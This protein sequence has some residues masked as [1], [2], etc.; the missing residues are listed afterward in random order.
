VV[1]LGGCNRTRI[2]NAA[3]TLAEKGRGGKGW[4]VANG[5]MGKIL[6][7]DLSNSGLRVEAL[8]PKLARD[9]IGGYG[10][11]A[12]LLYERMRPG[13]DPLGPEN[14]L[15]FVTGP[16]TGTPCIE[17]NRSLVVC[18]SPLTGGWGDANCGGTFGAG[19][20]FAGFD[21]VFFTGA[22]DRPV[23]L[24]I[25]DGRAMLHEA[26]DLWGHDTNETERVLKERH[27]NGTEVASI[28][29]AGEKLAL[30]AAI[31][32]DDGRAWGRSGVGAV[33]GSKKLKA[34]SVKGKQRVP[35]ANPERARDLRKEYLKKHTGAYDLFNDYGTPGI[36]AD[37]S[38]SG[39]TPVKNWFGAGPA[40]FPQGKTSFEADLIRGEYQDKKYGCW[41][42]TMACGG[43]W[44]VKEGPYKGTKHHQP[45]Y[46][47]LGSF[48][49]MMLND[50]VG[51][52]VKSN[53]ICNRMGL[54]TISAA[55][56]ISW[57]MDCYNRGILTS[58]DTD[59]IDLTWGNYAG[60]VAALE[61]LATRDGPF[62]DLLAQG[63]KRAA[64]QVGRG[65]EVCA[66]HVG[67]QEL[68][69][70][71]PRFIP[72]LALTYQLDATPGR[73]TQ[74]GEM[75]AWPDMQDVPDKYDYG[76]KG[77]FHRKLVGAMHF[78]NS[79]GVCQFG[80]GSYPIETWTAFYAAIVGQE[81]TWDE[82]LHIGERIANLRLA[83]N[84][85]ENINPLTAHA[86]PGIVVGSPPLATG[87]LRG[88]TVDVQRQ[89]TDYLQAAGW[90]PQTCRPSP[91]KLEELGLQ[92]LVGDLVAT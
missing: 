30:I 72:G 22:A 16:M 71:D 61:K 73:H 15:G 63:V 91:A 84:L 46:E 68:P 44:S 9:F 32:N 40:D 51:S 48:G 18:K 8:D 13:V 67:G 58:D 76:A 27:G 49:T 86:I 28:G 23:Y 20:K 77:E 34:V 5:Y 52:I 4:N 12:R 43:H 47:T 26:D 6:W 55:G 37:S 75:G 29:P 35:V 92:F 81:L 25:D 78:I 69:M 39:D 62:C 87:N 64:E 90:D 7:V 24:E 59:G 54:D 74:G 42:C 60:I 65:S 70:H 80:F 14:I 56:V 10:I 82:A 33:M 11:G 53:E 83:F 41:M 2:V 45:E 31:I 57:A 21:A 19:L 1:A 79:L 38:W 50:N 89:V 3:R 66:M 88:I 36:T 17:G 85:R